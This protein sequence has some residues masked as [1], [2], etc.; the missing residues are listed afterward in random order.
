M[1][2]FPA[3]KCRTADRP[4][5]PIEKLAFMTATPDSTGT[6]GAGTG[7]KDLKERVLARQLVA[8]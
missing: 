6:E 7:R 2:A 4:K 8:E 5:M 1:P 3:L